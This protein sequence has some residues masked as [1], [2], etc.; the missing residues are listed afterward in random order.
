[1]PKN[2]LGLTDSAYKVLSDM[3]TYLTKEKH[4]SPHAASAILGNVMQESTFDHNSVS[5]KGARGVYQLLGD[6][7][8]Y[9]KSFLNKNKDWKDGPLTMSHWIIDQ[10]YNGKDHYYE[11]YDKLKERQA[12]GW[13]ERTADGKG[14]YYNPQ[15]SIDFMEKYYPREKAGA[16]PPRREQLVK[17]LD[18]SKDLEEITRLFMDYWERPKDYEKKFDQRLKYSNEIYNHFNPDQSTFSYLSLFR[19]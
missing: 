4:L 11:T 2:V 3:Y 8:K 9:Y 1:M 16:L 15:D 17:A 18:N 10:T 19:R 7:Y 13:K 12:N 6:K 14:W 5:S